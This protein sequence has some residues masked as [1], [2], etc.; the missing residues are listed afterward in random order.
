MRIKGVFSAILTAHDI[1]QL[2]KKGSSG[3]TKKS[4]ATIDLEVKNPRTNLVETL[5]VTIHGNTNRDPVTGHT[6]NQELVLINLGP[7]ALRQQR[8]PSVILAIKEPTKSVSQPTRSI[9]GISKRR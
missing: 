6:N 7:V 4:N 5:H 8:R 3:A 1:E 9:N 2:V